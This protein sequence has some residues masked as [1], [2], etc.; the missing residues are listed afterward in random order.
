MCKNMNSFDLFQNS[1]HMENKPR[2]LMAHGHQLA[3]TSNRSVCFFGIK[4][5]DT[6]AGFKC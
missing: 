5:K 6:K 2:S 3:L 4:Q 1:F